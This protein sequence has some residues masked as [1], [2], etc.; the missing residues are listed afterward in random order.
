[1][2][3]IAIPQTTS[4]PQLQEEFYESCEI[5][6]K[7]N[8]LFLFTYKGLKIYLQ[9]EKCTHNEVGYDSF[10]FMSHTKFEVIGDIDCDVDKLI[11]IA[12]DHFSVTEKL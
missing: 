11:G 10:S 9:G 8:G 3:N 4:V 7:G 12:H 6:N 5:E 1:M 2:S